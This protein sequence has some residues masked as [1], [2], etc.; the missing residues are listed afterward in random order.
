LLR[1]RTGWSGRGG[2]A[3]ERA[4]L[5]P[6]PRAALRIQPRRAAGRELLRLDHRS[7]LAASDRRGPASRSAA[8]GALRRAARP[9]LRDYPRAS[10]SL[11]VFWPLSGGA[12]IYE[13][14]A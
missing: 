3:S 6:P 8:L 5:R 12:A 10:R 14:R 7:R 13:E 4:G 9:R 11:Y 2:S 1:R